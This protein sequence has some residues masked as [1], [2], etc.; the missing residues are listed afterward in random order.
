MPREGSLISRSSRLG[1][2][3]GTSCVEAEG[4]GSAKPSNEE[5]PTVFVGEQYMSGVS[6]VGVQSE[7][8]AGERE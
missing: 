3:E 7:T 4:L 2:G 6:K 5:Q 8:R 1:S